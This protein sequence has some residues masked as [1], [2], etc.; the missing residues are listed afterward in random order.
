MSSNEALGNEM[1][2]PFL[3]LHVGDEDHFGVSSAHCLESLEVSNLH[4]CFAVEFISC[5][6]H[7]FSGL[8][9][10]PCRKNLALCQPSLFRC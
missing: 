8:H 10:S 7:Q 2:D 4:G 5:L 3:V 9:I 1:V 6:S